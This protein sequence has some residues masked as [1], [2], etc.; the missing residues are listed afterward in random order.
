MADDRSFGDGTVL[1]KRGF[2]LDRRNPHAAD[3]HHVVS[4]ARVPKITVLV[5][6]V[7]VAG[8]DPIAAKGVFGLFVL[9]PIEG[10][11]SIA[12]DEQISDFAGRNRLLVFIEDASFVSR[13]DLAA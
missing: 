3:L 11:H 4:A 5:L 13:N 9:V 12:L 6:P 8:L 2:D 7:L 10:A 1:D